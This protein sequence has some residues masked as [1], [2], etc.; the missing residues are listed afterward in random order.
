MYDSFLLLLLLIIFL[1][2]ALFGD[3]STLCNVA[4]VSHGSFSKDKDVF[5][6][7]SLTSLS[8]HVNIKST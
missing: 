1:G 2:S 8:F 7:C 5:C 4:Q 6:L 3:C